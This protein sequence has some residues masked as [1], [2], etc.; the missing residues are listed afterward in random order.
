MSGRALGDAGRPP[1]G[2]RRVE[3]G[4][5][6]KVEKEMAK[7]A[8]AVASGPPAWIGA[9]GEG[10]GGGDETLVSWGYQIGRAHV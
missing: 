10:R 1:A 9:A 8:E 6:D 2:I 4:M 5:T 3:I 7:E